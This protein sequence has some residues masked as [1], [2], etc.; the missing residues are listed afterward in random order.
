MRFI[1]YCIYAKECYL[2]TKSNDFKAMSSTQIGTQKFGESRVVYENI[3]GGLTVDS[4]M[5]VVLLW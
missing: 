3:S 4:S 5:E 1:I 2:H